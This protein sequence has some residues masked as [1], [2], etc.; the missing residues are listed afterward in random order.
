M[1]LHTEIIVI[2]DIFQVGGLKKISI[3]GSGGKSFSVIL[4][5]MRMKE[6]RGQDAER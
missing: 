4:R 2:D 5:V 3:R 1:F 6:T